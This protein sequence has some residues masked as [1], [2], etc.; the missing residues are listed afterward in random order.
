[1][2]IPLPPYYYSYY[3]SNTNT[4]YIYIPASSSSQPP[5]L[6]CWILSKSSL[7]VL[8]DFEE[9]LP[10]CLLLDF[11]EVLPPDRIANS[12]GFLI[13]KDEMAATMSGGGFGEERY[14]YAEDMT[15]VYVNG[16][17]GVVGNSSDEDIY[18]RA[19]GEGGSLGELEEG[20]YFE[21][22]CESQLETDFTFAVFLLLLTLLVAVLIARLT[23]AYKL[24]WLQSSS[25]SLAMGILI[26][27]LSRLVNAL[28]GGGIDSAFD[29]FVAF[30]PSF[31]FI[32][33][34][35]PIIFNAGF[36]LDSRTFFYHSAAFCTFAFVGTLLCVYV[37]MRAIRQRKRE[38]TVHISYNKNK[39]KVCGTHVTLM[40]RMKAGD[41]VV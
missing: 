35:P 37:C 25:T 18:A 5:S 36:T 16:T 12:P 29:A 39:I 22:V 26:G 9:V 32:A 20:E 33:L 38:M 2:P 30:D 7:S 41:C 14:G 13:L 3:T 34:V 10:L 6:S 1:M 4:I 8:L 19:G 28:A 15:A 11:E 17:Q 31:F 23:T 27:G 24:S 40:M 21:E